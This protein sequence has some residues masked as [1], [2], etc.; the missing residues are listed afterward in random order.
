LEDDMMISSNVADFLLENV[1]EVAGPFSSNQTA[2][3]YRR[4]HA[5]IGPMLRQWT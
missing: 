2:F 1:F 5:N 3:A 4:L